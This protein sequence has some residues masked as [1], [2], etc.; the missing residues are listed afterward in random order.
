M[1][2]DKWTNWI[3]WWRSSVLCSAG[4]HIRVLRHL[5][6]FNCLIPQT[7][8]SVIYFWPSDPQ[9]FAALERILISL[10]HSQ[11]LHSQRLVNL[12]T[13]NSDQL[14]LCIYL[15]ER[16]FAICI[17]PLIVFFFVILMSDHFD[18]QSTLFLSLQHAFC[19][20]NLLPVKI[21]TRRHW[22][23]DSLLSGITL[24]PQ[25]KSKA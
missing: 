10:Q 24:L 14:C 6:C 22:D 16:P 13:C 25:R 20:L 15:K 4:H 21:N 3:S 11:L 2:E 8:A 5:C 9:L 12:F 7:A 23:L 1:S 17:C 18:T 19:K